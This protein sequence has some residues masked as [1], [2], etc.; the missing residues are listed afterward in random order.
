PLISQQPFCFVEL[1]AGPS[2]QCQV[3]RLGIYTHSHRTVCG[4][5]LSRPANIG[6]SCHCNPPTQKVTDA[7]RPKIDADLT[8]D[9]LYFPCELPDC[10]SRSFWLHL[11]VFKVCE[12]L[13]DE[14]RRNNNVE[15]ATQLMSIFCA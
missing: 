5:A 14:H 2:Q 4:P 12:D 9:R 1:V 6:H 15:I 10:G 11:R 13:E 8:L 3:L 7:K